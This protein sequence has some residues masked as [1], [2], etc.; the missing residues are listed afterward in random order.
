MYLYKWNRAVT[1]PSCPMMVSLNRIR[2]CHFPAVAGARAGLALLA[3][4]LVLAA[5][6]NPWLLSRAQLDALQAQYGQQAVERIQ[7]WQ[8]LLASSRGQSET[9]KL[10]RV[11]RFFN[12]LRFVSDQAHWGQEDYWATPVEFLATAGGDCEDFSIAKY[13]TLRALGV[14]TEKL[15]LIYVKATRINQAHMVLGY[16]A[17]PDAEPWILDNL[18]P[19]IRPASERPDLIPSYSFNGNSLWRAKMLREGGKKVGKSENIGIWKMLMERVMQST[20][21]GDR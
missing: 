2:P 11:N 19:R 7:D 21:A 17:T 9:E 1:L 6:G 16:Y 8:R 4:L 14:S 10:A 12:R 5:A 15:R 13:F 18:E 3:L 20:R